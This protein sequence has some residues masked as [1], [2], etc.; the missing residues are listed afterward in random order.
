MKRRITYNKYILKFALMMV[1]KKFPFRLEVL[2]FICVISMFYYYRR[3]PVSFTRN[4]YFPPDPG[5][6][7]KE[8]RWEVV[9]D[10]VETHLPAEDEFKPSRAV[11]HTQSHVVF[12]HG[13]QR[14]ETYSKSS[15]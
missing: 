12:V 15:E 2:R 7:N 14:F 5:Y 13:P 3:I 10:D 1:I 9:S 6:S 8:A 11:I 4:T